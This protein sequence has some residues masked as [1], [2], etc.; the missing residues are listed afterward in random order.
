MNDT[1]NNP[2][3]VA[4]DNACTEEVK[5]EITPVDTVAYLQAKEAQQNAQPVTAAAE[6]QPVEETLKA[7]EPQQPA[8]PDTPQQSDQDESETD[9]GEEETDE[10]EETA[11][12]EKPT[13]VKQPK[14][15]KLTAKNPMEQKLLDYFKSN[16][17]EALLKKVMDGRKTIQ[18]ASKYLYSY[19]KSKISDRDRHGEVC[20]YVDPEEVFGMFMHYMEDEKEGA[21][22]K[23]EAE[24]KAEEERKAKEKAEAEK[25]KAEAAAKK[26]AEEAEAARIAALTPEER[27]AEEKAKA[28]KK[29][30]EEAA[31][32]A[33]EAERKAKAEAER[34]A[35][36]AERRAH[37]AEIKKLEKDAYTAT[38]DGK[39]FPDDPNW[40]TEQKNAVKA[41]KKKAKDEIAAAKKAE[42][43]AKAAAKAKAASAQMDL[44]GFNV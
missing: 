8:T 7:E 2:F 17:S 19:A 24:I 27:A 16:A 31:K 1:N 12:A 28:E 30:A 38:K 9:E 41:G 35:K 40:T 34:K 20:V 44:F 5:A 29:A 33:A 6:P 36:E 39:D 42:R 14:E 26:A 4:I 43:E 18:G 23:T 3:C 22:Y 25:R 13:D 10:G 11:E 15:H 32:A 21:I 37:K